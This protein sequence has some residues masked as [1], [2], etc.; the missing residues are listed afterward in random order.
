MICM[1]RPIG[2]TIAAVIMGI[3]SIWWLMLGF[4]YFFGSFWFWYAG[5]PFAWIWGIMYGIMGFIGLGL[6][7]GLAA[8]Y[9]QAYSSTMIL[10]VL[11]L[12]FSIPALFSG[13]GITGAALSAVTLVLL[14]IPGV[15]G[16]YVR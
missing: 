16:F 9:R 8:G 14:L 6:A 4:M 12:A 1:A 10:A 15:K 5:F 7:G 11:F 13:Y 3:A 2:A